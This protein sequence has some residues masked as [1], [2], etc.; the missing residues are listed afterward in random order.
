MAMLYLH[1]LEVGKVSYRLEVQQLKMLVP[2][3]AEPAMVTVLLN[4]TKLLLQS[5]VFGH[6][7]NYKRSV[8]AI[9]MLFY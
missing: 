1:C 7:N 3:S 6:L 5:K 2:I 9:N 8:N 4:Q